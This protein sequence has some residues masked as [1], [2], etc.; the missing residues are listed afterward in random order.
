MDNDV[1]VVN[2]HYTVNEVKISC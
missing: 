2:M 1:T